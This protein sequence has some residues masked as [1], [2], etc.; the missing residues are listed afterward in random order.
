MPHARAPVEPRCRCL[1]SPTLLS[2]VTMAGVATV[3]VVIGYSPLAFFYGLFR[4]NLRIDGGELQKVTWGKHSF[5]LASGTHEIA[6]SYPWLFQPE[7]GKN[8]A[9]V[10][11]APGETARVRY[12]AGLIRYLPGKI[13]V[14]RI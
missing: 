1:D 8:T 3:E 7:C 6:I 11:L 9:R 2:S 10:Q 14:D 12:R 5:Q 13:T 4:P